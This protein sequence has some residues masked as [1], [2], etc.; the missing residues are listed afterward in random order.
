MKKILCLVCILLMLFTTNGCRLDKMYDVNYDD[1]TLYVTPMTKA[2]PGDIVKVVLNAKEGASFLLSV[3]NIE[4][5]PHDKD[6]YFITYEFVMPYHDVMITHSIEEEVE[7]TDITI[8]ASM[9]RHQIS[10]MTEHAF[11]GKYMIIRNSDDASQL[12][13][14]FA[15]HYPDQIQPYPENFFDNNI[16]IACLQHEGS[17]SVGHELRSVKMNG[18]MLTIVI[19]RKVPYIGTCD[20]AS[21]LCLIA[22][23]KAALPPAFTVEIETEKIEG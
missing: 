16:I 2:S 17:G 20:M 23:N 13:A 8:P 4:M 22:V 5:S 1:I 15:L 9:T 10:Y 12:F 7:M 21:W 19:Q 18:D 3:N 14:G 11:D 6:E